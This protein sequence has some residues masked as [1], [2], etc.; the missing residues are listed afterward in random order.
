MDYWK[1]FKHKFPK[2]VTKFTTASLYLQFQIS[3]SYSGSSSSLLLVGPRLRGDSW[4]GIFSSAFR[5][6]C[7]LLTAALIQFCLSLFS[8]QKPIQQS[9]HAII[10]TCIPESV[11]ILFPWL[12]N[13]N[14]WPVNPGYS[15]PTKETLLQA[16]TAS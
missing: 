11:S 1:V 2:S 6:Q 16:S 8:L 5:S 3:F 4:S 14:W 7:I 10:W 12:G 9:E 13:L 15:F